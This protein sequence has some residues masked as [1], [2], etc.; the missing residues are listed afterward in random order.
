MLN[1]IIVVGSSVLKLKNEMILLDR[2]GSAR[3][4]GMEKGI[5][6]DKSKDRRKR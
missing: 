6:E 4:E 5:R 2:N 1:D 3:V